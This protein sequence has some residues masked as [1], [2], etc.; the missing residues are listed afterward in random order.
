MSE[1]E[2]QLGLLV[3]REDLF[4]GVLLSPAQVK[5]LSRLLLRRLRLHQSADR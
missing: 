5:E 4:C 3:E 2:S 1:T